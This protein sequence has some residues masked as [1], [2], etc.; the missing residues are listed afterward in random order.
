MHPQ[1][2]L[3]LPAVVYLARLD[4][5]HYKVGVALHHS[6]RMAWCRVV[7]SSRRTRDTSRASCRF[8]TYVGCACCWCVWCVILALC[9]CPQLA[10][11]DAHNACVCWRQARLT[12]PDS[13]T[14]ASQMA[15][16]GRGSKGHY[17]LQSSGAYLPFLLLA[18][19]LHGDS[20]AAAVALP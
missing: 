1:L 19:A 4:P 18:L 12:A 13:H 10:L 8:V 17:I 5:Q 9:C 15:D 20:L 11:F 7:L 14:A 2:L 16:D 3:A 6:C